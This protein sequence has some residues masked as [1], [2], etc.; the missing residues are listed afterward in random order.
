MTAINVVRIELIKER[1]F[2]YSGSR[3]VRSADDAA[4]ILLEYIGNTDREEF[5]VM[6]LSTKHYVNALNTVSI[7]SLDASLVHPREVF[8][9]AILA[10]AS[11]IIVGHFHPSGDPT[12]SPEDIAVTKRL[13]EAGH[14]LGISVLDHIIIGDPGRFTSMKAH[15][16]M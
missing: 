12:P 11:D 13:V 7:G 2:K 16:L 1:N 6:V 14:M 4:S 10:N 15:G 5:V 8:K 9:P 3:Q